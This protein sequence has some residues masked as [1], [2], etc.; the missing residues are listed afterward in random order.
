MQ[1][2]SNKTV[3]S[4][5]GAEAMSEVLC[6]DLTVWNIVAGYTLSW[7]WRDMFSAHHDHL[8]SVRSIACV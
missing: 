8:E 3:V 4:C 7:L 1:A 5:W 2:S 6:D